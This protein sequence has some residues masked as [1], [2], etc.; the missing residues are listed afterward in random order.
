MV[1]CRG[2]VLSLMSSCLILCPCWRRDHGGDACAWLCG[3]RGYDTYT[4]HRNIV[5]HDY[6]HGPQTKDANAWARKW[7]E[8]QRSHERLKTL[9][10]ER[11]MISLS[12]SVVGGGG[13]GCCWIRRRQ[14][15]MDDS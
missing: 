15:R 10:G 8:L 13:G 6:T 5:F 3:C 14:S 9:L 1:P 11:V 7:R 4:P 2:R 12:W